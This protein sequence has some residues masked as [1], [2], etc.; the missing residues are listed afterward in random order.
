MFQAFSAWITRVGHSTKEPTDTA[1]KS[2]SNRLKKM[3]Y[4]SSGEEL[5][6]KV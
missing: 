2:T 3:L 4:K 1:S 5:D 6:E